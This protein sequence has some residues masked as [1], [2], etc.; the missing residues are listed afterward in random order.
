MP[1]YSKRDSSCNKKIVKIA[2][3][4]KDE[5]VTHDAKKLR[6]PSD[7][8]MTF[9]MFVNQSVQGS[10]TQYKMRWRILFS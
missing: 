5:P 9:D 4:A 8:R 7:E 10:S 1:R 6:V 3:S 2:T